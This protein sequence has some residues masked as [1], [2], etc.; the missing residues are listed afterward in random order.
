MTV[1]G[2]ALS[3]N[4]K[5]LAE[6]QPTVAETTTT[7][8]DD[9]NSESTMPSSTATS[10]TMESER[11]APTILGVTNKEITVDQPF[12]PKAGVTATDEKDGDLTSKIT[13]S[14]SIN[15]Q[16]AGEY[17]ITYSVTNAEG[18][19]TQKTSMVRVQAAAVEE[20]RVEMTDFTLY[21][22]ATFS[23]EI[24]QRM[25]IKNSANEIVSSNDA[26]VTVIGEQTATQLGTVP[27]AFTV[28]L[29]N[30][31]TIAHTVNVTVKSG[32]RVA[33][34]K[35]EYTYRGS[36]YEDGLDLMNYIEAYESD[37]QGKETRMTAYNATTKTG[38]EVIKNDLN[39]SVPGRYAIVYRLT[40]SFGEVMEHTSF[41]TVI[42]P[43]DPLKPT[44]KVEDKTM[45]VGDRL[46]E[47]M[48]IE[49]AKTE[50]AEQVAFEVINGEIQ[51]NRL[52]DKLVNTGSY[53]IRFT[54]SRKDE[55]TGDVLTE[56]AEMV[57]TVKEKESTSSP[58]T[59][60]TSTTITGINN[61]ATAQNVRTTK[62]TVP[63]T[64]AKSLPKTGSE[65]GNVALILS[66][67]ALVLGTL[68][69]GVRKYRETK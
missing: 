17:P 62:G 51:V 38:I 42:K 22:N 11:T 19:E 6:E 59:T 12:D 65:R 29:A 61:V 33:A 52:T 54:A 15:T 31:T 64:K 20:Y 23:N 24:H 55:T 40:N 30:G 67:V 2:L 46:T 5:A 8:N 48:I 43:K 25:I 36:R 58:S 44:I 60:N 28:K 39:V 37:G 7:S 35:E 41:V 3:L 66:G 14:G 68:G 10:A 16:A 18:L 69:V 56:Q 34:P 21:K 26:V 32:I 9:F 50:N 1:L 45:Y 4:Q 53:T 27:V 57:L 49:W 13:V 47:E 63:S